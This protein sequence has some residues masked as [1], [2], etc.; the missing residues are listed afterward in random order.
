[1]IASTTVSRRARVA[2]A[3]YVLAIVGVVAVDLVVAW[4]WSSAQTSNDV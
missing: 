4:Q 2:W 3:V 1:M